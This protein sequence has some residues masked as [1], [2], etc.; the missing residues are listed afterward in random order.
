ATLVVA[1]NGDRV[2]V[3]DHRGDPGSAVPGILPRTLRLSLPD[4]ASDFQPQIGLDPSKLLPI[5]S[6]F[7]DTSPVFPGQH[8]VAYTFRIGYAEGVAELHATLPYNTAKL[9]FLGPDAGLEFRTDVLA[10]AG[11]TKIEGNSYRVLGADNLKADS[12]V[13]VDVVG[14]PAVPT[15]RLSPQDMQIGGIAIIVL[16]VVLATFLGFRS[17]STRLFDPLAER[18]ALLASIARL[19]DQYAAGQ[20]GAERYRAER[21]QQKRQLIDLIVGARASASGPGVA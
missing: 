12:T 2:Y 8:D 18:R 9:R 11:T 14:L 4:G 17:R 20:L 13:T 16:A 5:E 3:G 6:G 10:D 21:A 15:D 7:V 19:D 1:N